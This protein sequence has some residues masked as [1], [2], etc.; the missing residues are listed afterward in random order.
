[1]KTFVKALAAFV[2]LLLAAMSALLI[3]LTV[4]RANLPYENGRY[5][6]TT[7]SVVYD[8]EAVL[9][10]GLLAAIFTL[11]TLGSIWATYRSWRKE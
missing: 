3:K 7:D 9:V 2:S 1:M 11:A 4:G 8:E 6:D 10:Y 5:F